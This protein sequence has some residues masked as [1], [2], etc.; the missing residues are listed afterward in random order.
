[1]ANDNIDIQAVEP[2]VEDALSPDTPAETVTP[3]EY[4]ASDITVLEGLEAVRKRPGM[5]IGSTGLRGLHHLVYE[6]VDNS[7]DEALAGYCTHIEVVLQADGGVKVVDDG[8]GIPVDMHPTEHKPTVEVVMTILHAGGKF[9]GGGYA[10]SGGLHGVGISVV[11]ALS[12]RVDTEVRRQGYV[13]RMSFAD[14]GKPQGG[15]V[16]GDETDSTGTTQ[17]FYPD[18]GIFEST[19][20]DFETLRARFQQMAFLNKGLRITLTDE[21]TSTED[22]DDDL[23]LDAVV[24]EG[25]VTAEHRTVVYQYDDGLLDYVK[26]LNS[27]KK[28]DVVHEDVIAFETEDKERHIAVEMAM[29]WTSAYSESVHTYAN[30]IN[31]HE[32]GTHEEGF[33]AA[34]TSLINRYARE[35]SIIKEKDD[36]LTGDDIREGLTAVISVKLAEP[37]FEGQTKTKL[38]NSEVKGFVQRVVTDQLGDWL[39]RNPGPARD[40]IRKAISAA[41]ARMAARKARDNARRKSPL[42][43]FG[44]P[45]KLSDCSSK[46]P[47]KCEVYL[48]EGDSAGGSAKRGRNPE[49]QAIL[50]LRGKI[51]NVERARLDKAL[52]NAE[53]Q[54]M[55]TAFGTGIGEDFDLAKLRYHKIVLMA[56]AD[57]D[58]QHITTLLMTLLF[59]YMRPLIENGYVY[60]AQPPLYRIKWSN[61][62]HD[63]VFSDKQRDAKLLSGQ[64]AGRRIPKD[65]GIQRYK[66]LGEMDYTELWDTTMDPDHRTLLQVT[67]DDALAADQIFSVLMGEDVESRRNFIQQNAKDVRFLDI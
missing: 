47:A 14:G 26:H 7:V 2:A 5:Y 40:V 11:N 9:G 46:D 38:G 10:V 8:R 31:T 45:G 30:T 53:V 3:R 18:A 20:F 29:Q 24:T 39:E 37:Q 56:D 51:L 22:T 34:M 64:A 59:R 28:V 41:Q 36:N 33:R 23:D 50:P 57:V 44:M 62:P 67:M 54:S 13:W 27:G 52:G 4:G 55:I 66:G 21:R 12:S 32:G 15:L 48:V 17:T 25:E 35:K 16:R 19:E 58:G 49:T 43:S 60:L 63:Y 6:V 61:A 42:E 65:N 1:M